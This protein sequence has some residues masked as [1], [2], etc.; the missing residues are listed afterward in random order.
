MGVGLSDEATKK[1]L[2]LYSAVMFAAHHHLHLRPFSTPAPSPIKT[3]RLR[4]AAASSM[5]SSPS[6]PFLDF[7]HLSASHRRLMLSIVSSVHA[8][9]APDLLPSSLPP[10]V[11]YFESPTGTSKGTL[12][13]VKGREG[14]KIDFVLGSWIHC[15]LPTGSSL[16]IATVF[17]FLSATTDAPHLLIEF[18]QSS[19]TSLVLIVDL[20][21]RKD[22]VL[23]PEYLH[24][25]YE[26]THLENQRRELSKLPEAKPFLSSSLYIRSV[27]SPTALSVAI[28][29]AGGR[30]AAG[31][32]EEVEGELEG[33]A[34]EV[35]GIWL[36][37]C[38]CGEGRVVGEAEKRVLVERDNL[39]KKKAVEIDLAANLPRLFGEETAKRLVAAIQE[40]FRV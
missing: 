34:K 23:N 12:D 6:R 16:D 39:V 4:Q 29:C 38:A 8:R 40:V 18:I 30:A 28:D 14:S 33:V 3:R 1:S 13:I 5:S 32:M 25:F 37:G 31:R 7:P 35:V 19:P 24:T 21:P 9:L 26:R 27:L 11:Q 20:L 17:A 10:D 36:E 2:R 15:D 22:L